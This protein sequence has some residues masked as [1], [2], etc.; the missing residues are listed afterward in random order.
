MIYSPL[1]KKASLIAFA[2]HKE[3]FDKGGYPYVMH[4]FY[5][6]FQMRDE[7]AV[8][9]ALLHDVI[10]DHADEYSFEFL[11][12][13]GF[14]ESV[15]AP[16]RLLTHDPSVPY[17]DYVKAIGENPT[18]RAVKIADLA[19]NLDATRVGGKPFYKTDL[20]REALSYL[21]SL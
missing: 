11:A 16:L 19:H 6:A 18:A 4:P 1:V 15:L 10:E 21:K 5:L 8:C 14:P 20:Y 12:A 17:M 7:A 2:A 3:D 9:A 13:E